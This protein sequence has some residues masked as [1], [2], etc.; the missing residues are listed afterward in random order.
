MCSFC[1]S[2]QERAARRLETHKQVHEH[3]QRYSSGVVL[4]LQTYPT[5]CHTLDF[6]K[7]HKNIAV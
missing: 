7:E 2:L 3:E 1:E 5:L 4:T 6:S